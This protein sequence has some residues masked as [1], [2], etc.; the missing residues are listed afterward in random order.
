[1][2]EDNR[3]NIDA[4]LEAAKDAAR[5]ADPRR[6]VEALFDSFAL[7]G[8]RIRLGL[9]WPGIHQDDINFLIA[10]AVDVL[11]HAVQGGDRVLSLPGYLWKVADRK[12]CDYDARRQRDMLTD[13]EDLHETPKAEEEHVQPPSDE[14]DWEER[15]EKA[16]AVA[17]SLLPKL[18][19]KNLQDVLSYVIE[20]V[21]AGRE[22]VPNAEIAEALGLSSDTVRTSLSRG[23]RRLE[24]AAR[25]VGLSVDAIQDGLADEE[26]DATDQEV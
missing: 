4:A 7:D 18:G 25:E 22:D 14:M 26:P 6:M 9:K 24:R 12:A 16:V 11:Y 15:R 17:R 2:P 21:E 8:I 1:M 13:M 20:A 23:F 19:Q 3:P 10:E 5:K